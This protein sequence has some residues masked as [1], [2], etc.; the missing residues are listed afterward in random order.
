LAYVDITRTAYG[1][2]VWTI[3]TDAAV[4]L[5]LAKLYRVQVGGANDPN[6]GHI[7]CFPVASAE[8]EYSGDRLAVEHTRAL[9]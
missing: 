3:A 9:V 7:T 5:G 1:L 4:K 6:L 8:R 2:L